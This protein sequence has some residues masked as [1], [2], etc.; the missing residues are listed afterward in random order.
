[1]LLSGGGYN[2]P[3]GEPHYIMLWEFIELA[4]KN[5][6]ELRVMVVEY[7]KSRAPSRGE[8]EEKD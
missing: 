7:G 8:T 5:G 2:F 4:K 1:M 6:K 3:A